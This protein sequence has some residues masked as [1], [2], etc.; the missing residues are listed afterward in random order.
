MKKGFT[1]V[2]LMTVIIILGVLA[3]ITYPIVDKSIKQS[4]EKAL[5]R[6]IKSIIDASYEYSIENDLGYN[7]IYKKLQFDT[8]IDAGLLKENI[9]NPVT[10]QELQGCVLYRWIDDYKQYEFEYSETCEIQ[11]LT[12]EDVVL[13]NFP[14][15]EV[16]ENGC[17]NPGDNNYSYMGGC[18][19]KG[20]NS[21]R[22][23]DIFYYYMNQLEL[24]NET[25]DKTFFDSEGNFI[26][27]NFE[28]FMIPYYAELAEVPEDAIRQMLAQQGMTMFELFFPMSPKELFGYGLQSVNNNSLWYSGFLW[29]IMGINADG[30]IRL[31]TEE[32]ITEIPWGADGTGH[33]WD[34]SHAN[35][36]LNNYFYPRLKGNDIIV[37]QTWCSE[38]TSGE[39]EPRTTCTENLSK[40]PAK[41]GLITID[42]YILSGNINSYL[43]IGQGQW[44]M[45]PGRSDSSNAYIN[46]EGVLGSFDSTNYIVNLQGIRAVINIKNDIIIMGGNGLLNEH[47]NIEEGPY[48]FAENINEEKSKKLNK[49]ATSGEYVMFAGKKYRVVDKDGNGNIQ[50]ILDGYYEEDGNIFE[51]KYG[52]DNVFSLS[53][54]IGQKLNGD[55][56]NWITNNDESEKAKLVSD[57]TW[58]QNNF[59][60]GQSYKVSLNEKNPTRSINATVGLIRVGEML[61]GQSS[62]ILTKGYIE[63]SSYNNASD[64]WTMTS[65]IN[66]SSIWPVTNDCFSG[67]ADVSRMNS[68]RPVIVIKSD[69]E[70]IGGTGTWSNP[71]QI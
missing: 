3:L 46:S 4:K 47:W 27:K 1:L 31:I 55:V 59:D 49:K 24:N 28:D 62:S 5:D 29:R 17:K 25:I 71:Y 13:S 52:D 16:G 65:Y 69:V 57:Y 7:S 70:I 15:L 60:S 19:L 26:E 44:T 9:I 45:T 48:I 21:A 18:Y 67:R 51:M 40:N 43:N 23:K 41:V 68:L 58:Y 56:L 8:L 36:W 54:G 42:E 66:D 12:I 20:K 34:G 37:D 14:Y 53:T 33:N 22:G 50:L 61:S 32:N 63:T 11:I 35:D 6:T 64:Y 10:N 30:T 38:I 2:E 39:Q